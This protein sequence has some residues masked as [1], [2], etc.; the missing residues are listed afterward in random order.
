MVIQ[1]R[2]IRSGVVVKPI[3]FSAHAHN[4]LRRRGASEEEVIEAIRTSPWQPAE[5]GRL[6]CR[7]DFAYNSEWNGTFYA[8]KRVRPIFVEEAA[9]IIVVTVYSY[10]F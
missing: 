7:Q 5:R 9:E 4:Q 1:M 8:T 3:R 6:E 2:F 10:Y